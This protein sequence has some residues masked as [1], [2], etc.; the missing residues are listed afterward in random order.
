MAADFPLALRGKMYYVVLYSS[1][2][3]LFSLH[4]ERV[5]LLNFAQDTNDHITN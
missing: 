1:V 3:K 4:H 5:M 2:V